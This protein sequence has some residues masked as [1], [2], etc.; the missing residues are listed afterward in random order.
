MDLRKTTFV[1][2]AAILAAATLLVRFVG[3]LYRLPLT[4]LI[5]D[6]G[7]AYYNVGYQ[8]YVFFLMLS[9][10]GLPAA[11]SKMVSERIAL[12]QYR[13]AHR[14]FRVALLIA[15][16]GGFVSAVIVAAGGRAIAKAVGHPESY[17]SL[18]T[19]SPTLLIVGVM[20]VYRGYFQGMNNTVPT[21]VSQIVEQIF[22][23]VFSVLLAYLLYPKGPEYG[24]AGGT[25]G[26]GVGALAGLLVM[27]GVYY[28]FSPVLR[29]RL[30]H[31]DPGKF[32]SSGQMAKE[33]LQ[34]A[35]PIILGTAIFSMSNII[36]TFM[37]T[38]SLESLNIY[39]PLEI[40]QKFGQ[41]S[42]KYMT[43]ITLP[44]SV[45]T[46]LATAAVPSVASSVIRKDRASVNR[47]IN[48]G[49]RLSMMVSIP[50]AIGM[51]ALGDQIIAMLFPRHAE[52]GLLLQWGAASVIFLALAQIVTGMLQGI[53][54]VRI[55]V[56][57]AICG[58]LIKIPLNFW[59]IRQPAINI[60]GAVVSTIVCYITASCIDLYFLL[61]FT[62]ASIDF[63]NVFF[64]PII[65][66]LVMGLTCYVTYY[67]MYYLCRRNAVST[68]AAVLI[69]AGVYF[70][71]MLFMKGINRSDLRAIPMGGKVTALMNR[72]GI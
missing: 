16:I 5:G 51:S 50:A 69:G 68:I 47:K 8:I 72:L 70:I 44:V 36:D 30:Q 33:I 19:L 56:L 66:S 3:F 2:Q 21:A 11:I 7:N 63:K 64:K 40:T 1:R 32:H 59:L 43:L 65:G 41:L 28:L 13:Q 49:I 58:A 55:P 9:S 53:G 46:A 18:L 26:T 45:S 35:F 22:N 14:V 62:Q 23:A 6:Q 61:K 52:G 29:S 17:Y 24:A 31:A 34:T 10:A 42:G 4:N 54:K 37:V 27:L 20:A 15:A 38:S 48:Q 25:A 12:K 57:G 71:A 39:S 67:T 60:V